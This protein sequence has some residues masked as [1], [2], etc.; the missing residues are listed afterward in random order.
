MDTFLKPLFLALA[1]I[2]LTA[3]PAAAGGGDQP[4]IEVVTL[5]LKPGVS[6][7]D[8]AP[9]DLAVERQHVSKHP[10]FLSRE[11]AAGA[12]GNWLVIVKWASA[13]DADASMSTFMKA[14]AAAKFMSMIDAETMVMKRHTANPRQ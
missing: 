4:V 9:V 11:T 6:H 3:V 2:G 7:R 5:K 14:P 8:F 12:D 10:G 1:V 13:K